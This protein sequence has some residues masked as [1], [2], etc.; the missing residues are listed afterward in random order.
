MTIASSTLT[1]QHWP[2]GAMPK[3][4][5]ESLFSRMSFIYG[6]RFADLWRDVDLDGL[7]RYWA[8]QLGK[9]TPQELKA[10]VEKLKTKDWPPTL[11]EFE[12][13]CRPSIDA[14]SAYYEALE[15]GRA[16]EDGKPNVW[17]SPAIYWAWRAVGPYEFRSQSFPA[18]KSRW[19]KALEAQLGRDHWEPIP[20]M[21]VAQ[22]GMSKSGNTASMAGV[23]D[24]RKA[25]ASMAQLPK[26]G[27]RHLNWARRVVEKVK[28]GDRSLPS[29]AVRMAE[30]AL[31]NR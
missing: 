28:A 7:K 27:E 14:E 25:V 26:S 29:I 10:G 8:I 15:Q 30:E 5:V 24:I 11:A 1:D 22:I 3:A 18:L 21:P 9:Y 19:A 4:W 16:R 12:K 2:D 13:L 6:A 20:D 31:R 17:S 23:A